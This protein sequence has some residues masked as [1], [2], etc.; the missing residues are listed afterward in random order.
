LGN[1]AI[2][3]ST[4][5]TP[6]PVAASVLDASVRVSSGSPP[7]SSRWF[8]QKDIQA[9]SNRL[10]PWLARIQYTPLQGS[11]RD[12]SGTGGKGFGTGVAAGRVDSRHLRGAVIVGLLAGFLSGIFG[13]GG[14]ILIVPGLVLALGMEQRRAH[15]TSLA[16]AIPISISG[17]IGYALAGKVDWPVSV[18]II[19]GGAIGAVIGTR[20]LRRLSSM[21]LRIAFVVVLVAA[22]ARLAI[23][24]PHAHERGPF[25]VGLALGLFALGLGSGIL[26]GL[27]GVGGG[28][29]IVPALLIFWGL[30]SPVAKGTSL[31]V[32]VVTAMVGTAQN[33]RHHNVDVSVAI[34][35]GLAGTLSAFGATKIS[36]SLNGNISND[37]FALLLIAMAV[38]ML[39]SHERPSTAAHIAESTQTEA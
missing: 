34:W 27:M 6:A 13:V 14:G 30:S 38:R 20:F 31:A 37:L 16:T 39:M 23:Q 26:A 12:Q 22:A 3:S 35:A 1:S 28:I 5:P 15:G 36:V 9:H 4:A 24:I 8:D 29:V 21:V 19:V 25:G 33:L 32:V 17:L 18:P 2:V 10:S 7:L 11:P